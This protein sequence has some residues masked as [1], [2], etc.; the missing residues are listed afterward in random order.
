MSEHSDGDEAQSHSSFAGENA[1]ADN[2]TNADKIL[3]RKTL[4]SKEN[5]AVF[6]VRG[7]VFLVLLGT[8][9]LVSSIVYLY[10]RN[11]QVQDFENAFE[12][13]ATKIVESFYETVERKLEAIDALSVTI[14]SYAKSTG[15]T[16]PNVTLP[17]FE[18]RA[19]NS[20]VLSDSAVF[21]Y[22]PVVTDETRLAW[23]AYTRL[24]TATSS[25]K[26]WLQ[27]FLSVHTKMLGSA[28]SMTMAIGEVSKR[29]TLET[30]S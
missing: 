16:F 11:D 17:D 8:A 18:I 19:S 9:A 13:H 6:W 25:M 23:E 26:P 14:T 10:T 4:A 15:A 21:N 30:S 22:Q 5:A 29:T 7:A 3:E 27:E 12:A 2:N 20:R 24:K 1:N 28:S